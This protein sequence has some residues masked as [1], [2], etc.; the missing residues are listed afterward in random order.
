MV[1][2]RNCTFQRNSATPKLN[3]DPRTYSGVGGA[4]FI[5]TATA[6]IYDCLFSSNYALSGQFDSGAGGG[7]IGIE[8]SYEIQIFDSV[9]ILN[10]ARG[11]DHTSSYSTSGSGG[12]IMLLFSTAYIDTCLFWKNLVTAGGAEFSVGG[13][14]TAFYDVLETSTSSAV[15]PLQFHHCEFDGN[16]ANGE[17]CGDGQL[18]RAGQGGAVGLVGVSSS[19]VIFNDTIFTR[20]I[21]NTESSGIM[22]SF[23]GA[24]YYTGGSS[25]SFYRCSLLKNVAYNGFGDDICSGLSGETDNYIELIEPVLD[26]V[27]PVEAKVIHLSLLTF[28]DEICDI[29]LSGNSDRS[30]MLTES[31]K[32][33]GYEWENVINKFSDP[34]YGVEFVKDSATYV[35]VESQRGINMGDIFFDEY[36]NTRPEPDRDLKQYP[37]V[38][39][40]SGIAKFYEPT[41][42]NYSYQICA[43]DIITLLADQ[44]QGAETSN[45]RKPT[46]QIVGDVR[47]YALEI[48]SLAANVTVIDQQYLSTV[49]LKSLLIVNSTLYHSNNINVSSFSAIVGSTCSSNIPPSISNISFGANFVPIIT[50]RHIVS[51]GFT[52]FNEDSN[53]PFIQLIQDRIFSSEIVLLRSSMRIVGQMFLSTVSNLGVFESNNTLFV[54]LSNRSTIIVETTG[55]IIVDSM[56]SI[57]SENVNETSVLNA[58]LINIVNNDDENIKGLRVYGNI[59][60]T[61][62]ATTIIRIS[63]YNYDSPALVMASNATFNGVLN[64]STIPAT[65]MI[66]SSDSENPSVWNIIEY[67]DSVSESILAAPSLRSVYPEGLY[68]DEDIDIYDDADYVDNADLAHAAAGLTVNL[69]GM[70]RVT[71]DE[72]AYSSMDVQVGPVFNNDSLSWIHSITSSAMSCSARNTY[73]N[74]SGNEDS[75]EYRCHVCLLNETCGFC[76]G[77]ISGGCQSSMEMCSGGTY[78]H[79][80]NCCP[81]GCN[82]RGTCEANDELTSFTCHCDPFWDG[83]ACDRLSVLSFLLIS[84]GIFSILIALIILRYYFKYRHQKRKVLDDLREN[85]LGGGADHANMSHHT[86][87]QG[88]QQDLILRDVFVPYD[89]IKVEKKIGEGSFGEV[90]MATFR[91][92]QVAVKQMR[93]PVFLQFT[94]NDIEE[95]RKEAYM[96]SRLRHPNIVLV[97]GVS[98][99]EQEA[100]QPPPGY[101]DDD[102]VP[103]NKRGASTD[104][105]GG[106]KRTFSVDN[107]GNKK[108]EPKIRSVCIITEYLEQGSLADILYGNNKVSDDVWTYELVLTCALQA[109][110]GMLYLHSYQPPICHRDLKSSNLV[111]DDHW[112]VKVTDF[113]MS[114]IVPTKIRNIETGIVHESESTEKD[115]GVDTH[116]IGEI[117][118][119][120]KVGFDESANEYWERESFIEVDNS[121]TEHTEMTSNLGTTAWCAPEL[122]AQGIKTKYSVKVDVYSFGVVLWELWERKKPYEEMTSR[123]DIIDAVRAGRRPPISPNCPPTYRSLIQ[124]CWHELPA[125]RPT[126][127]Y[128]VR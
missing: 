75:W 70:Q 108:S 27:T 63:E 103:R 21:A 15:P 58:G 122:L 46:L 64:V 106:K 82:N 14:V 61:V 71:T 101:D 30:L 118:S 90:Y 43:A 111:V 123:F 40:S 22:S 84:V 54:H 45:I 4:I 93:T 89:E 19:T 25:V 85:L 24:L 12:A 26:A 80:D 78:F 110:R 28:L 113:G 125:R 124:R 98:I 127:A 88:I 65:T 42:V 39:I 66:P 50:Y 91:G 102:D 29:A 77:S 79:T 86:Y 62:N 81:D 47:T 1:N 121:S 2:I 94:D 11:Y 20:N 17:I 72:V 69:R 57:V 117:V 109:A 56:A 10:S 59:Y 8:N 92:A 105:Q 3:L 60:Q 100:P 97:M 51:T 32:A 96:M 5:E 7:A 68:F 6:N 48:V 13:A 112:V 104:S 76:S 44:G 37:S 126:F 74:F 34:W 83:S 87:L 116:G 114:R 119:D 120:R 33:W 16:S 99:L 55:E 36:S 52:S 9:F 31:M 35:N 73:Y 67:F 41:F 53:L 49:M 95:F 18:V 128:I 38:L 107:R 23:G 115:I